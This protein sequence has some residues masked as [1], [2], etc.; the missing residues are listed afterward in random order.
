MK[1]LLV[2]T[3]FASLAAPLVGQAAPA[4]A[5]PPP[6]PTNRWSA[7]PVHS[8]VNFRVRHLGITWVNGTFGQWTADLTFD[9]TKPE[10]ASVSAKIQSATI[11]TGNDRSDTDIRQNYL[12]VDS[13]PEITFTSTK[14]ERTAP[15][16]LRITGDLTMRGITHPVVLETDI[17]GV[18]NTPRG[19][20]TAFSATTTLKRQDYGIA[21]NRFMEGAQVVG[22]DVRITIDV[23]ATEK[24]TTP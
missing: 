19:R 12:A 18:L 22:D 14:V 4:A 20:R 9:P 1:T 23:E 8:A 11:T 2:L 21:L 16:H 15:D 10:A 17:G 13:F 5:A 7:D 6:T 3:A 24:T